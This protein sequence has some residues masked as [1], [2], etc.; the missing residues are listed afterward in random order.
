M[1]GSAAMIAGRSMPGSI[2][3]T[4]RDTAI[5]APVLPALTQACASPFLTSSTATRIDE[6]FL[7]RSARAGDSSI[8]TTS[9][10]WCTRRRG[11][12]RKP[13]AS[14]SASMAPMHFARRRLD[15]ERRIGEEIVSAVH[16]ALRRGFLVLLD[17]HMGAPS[18][19]CHRMVHAR[20]MPGHHRQCQDNLVV[21][22]LSDIH[23]AGCEHAVDLVVGF[24]DLA[25]VL[26]ELQLGIDRDGNRERIETTLTRHLHRSSYRQPQTPLAVA[27][28]SLAQ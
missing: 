5:S 21:D 8:S 18:I 23:A 10:A 27:C 17:C 22:K 24:R 3:R 2:L 4:K 9:L 11:L 28:P 15:R 12:A 7:L 14:S 13:R 25:Q 1:L 19:S 6:S 16:A 26:R 20:C